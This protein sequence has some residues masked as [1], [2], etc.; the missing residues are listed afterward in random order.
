VNWDGPKG[1]VDKL[2]AG[3]FTDGVMEDSGKKTISV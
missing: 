2:V 3:G 1:T